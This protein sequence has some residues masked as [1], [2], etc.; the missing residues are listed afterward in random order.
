MPSAAGTSGSKRSHALRSV[1][2]S[3]RGLL[4]TASCSAHVL[5][6]E[7]HAAVTEGLRRTG[8]RY[9]E[10]EQVGH[11]LDHPTTFAEA[12]YLKAVYLRMLD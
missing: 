2:L 6:E 8:R 11:A 1:F 12:R 5:A 7:F 9:E 4:L 10:L 3:L